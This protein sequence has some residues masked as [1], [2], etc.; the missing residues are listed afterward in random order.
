MPDRFNFFQHWYPISPI[1]DLDP[2]HPTPI[3]LLGQRV[4]VW[5]PRFSAQYCVF[6][7]QC[8]HRLAPLSE[9]RVDDKTGHLMCSYHGWQFDAQGVCT[10]IP[11]AED[12]DLIEK[13]REHYCVTALPTQEANGLLWVWPDVDSAA[14][15]HAH[16]LPLSPQVDADR[17]FV[18]SSMVRDLEYDWQ[19]LIENVAD[20]SHVPF[21]HHG[22]Q[23]NR[24]NAKPLDLKIVK[25]TQ[26]RIEAK[27][28]RSFKTQ[29]TFTPPCH[30]EY[31]MDFGGDRQLGLVTYCIP[32]SPGKSRIIAQFTRNFAKRLHYWTPRW[33]NHLTVRNSVLDGD[34]VLLH[35]QERDLQQRSQTESWKTAYKLPTSAD[36]MV[37]EFRRW[38]DQYGR[39]QLPW[40]VTDTSTDLPLLDRR[41]LLDR[42]HQHTEICGSCRQALKN[43]QRL[44][45]GLLVYFS[46]AVSV[47]AV[48]PDRLR[49]WISLPLVLTA[50][51]GLII[52]AGLQYWL[53]PKFYF[54]DYVHAKR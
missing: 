21:A 5:K 10:H 35:Y 32:V 7:D 28:E 37:I 18:W 12:P 49:G 6:R 1:E 44:Q 9:G 40:D 25:S 30:L 36:R 22:V 33:W 38:L 23:G 2:E 15:A 51:L 26:D 4:V 46:V 45:I 47:A 42:Y 17:G 24:N 11:Q 52:Y 20:P 3:V 16:P 53:K 14:I 43:L 34:M 50:L 13:N 29:I 54:V 27:T 31:A 48:M 41:Q 19:T 8:P 39:G